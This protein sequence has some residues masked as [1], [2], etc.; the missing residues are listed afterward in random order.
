MASKALHA[1]W[2][3]SLGEG[4]HIVVLDGYAADECSGPPG[5]MCVERGVLVGGGQGLGQ[6]LSVRKLSA[7]LV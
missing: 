7:G 4:L 5:L 3:R 1:A 2:R 6:G